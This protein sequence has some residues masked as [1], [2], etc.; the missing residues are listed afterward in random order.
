MCRTT[1]RAA[2]QRLFFRTRSGGACWRRRFLFV[3]PPQGFA[4]LAAGCNS[5]D[6]DEVDSGGRRTGDCT[7]RCRRRAAAD[8]ARSRRAQHRRQLPL[9][10]AVHDKAAKCHETCAW[11]CRQDSPS[12]VARP[13][14]QPQRKPWRLPGRL[15]R[16]RPL[17]PQRG[18]ETAGGQE[19]EEVS[20]RAVELPIRIRGC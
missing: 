16:I 7:K 14:L 15:G 1:C 20:G 5:D 17:H 13:A 4:A 8:P 12:A 18:A 2:K 19:T 10:I 6:G 11:L 9:A 3:L